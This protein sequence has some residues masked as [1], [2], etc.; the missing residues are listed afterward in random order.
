[1]GVFGGWGLS[2]ALVGYVGST[3]NDLYAT[4]RPPIAHLDWSMIGKGFGVA[5]GS[6]LI[7][8]AIPL[9]QASRTAPINSLRPTD[10]RDRSHR[11][12]WVLLAAGLFFLAAAIVL[13]RLPGDSPAIGFLMALL[14]ASG[15]A[16]LCPLAT[17]SLASLAGFIGRRAQMM[18]IQ[19]AA[20]GVGHSLR[21]TGVAVAAMMLAAAMNVALLTMIGSFRTAVLNW[22][23]Q[24][25]RSDVFVAPELQIDYRIDSV[26]DPRVVTWIEAQ[27]ET[28]DVLLYRRRALRIGSV[29][30]QLISTQVSHVL[31]RHMLPFRFEP[32]PGEAF[33]PQAD[34]LVSEPL[35]GKL[36]VRPGQMLDVETP[37][38]PRAF[39]IF[40]IYFD[41]ASDRGEAML[42]RAAYAEF[43]NDRSVSSVHVELKNPSQVREVVTRW[44][45]EL[46]PT[47]PV[48][49]HN[50]APREIG[51]RPHLRPDISR[52]RC[53]RMDGGRS[54]FLWTGWR[55]ASPLD[56]AAARV[57][58]P[59]ALGMSGRQT[60]AWVAMEGA[61]IAIVATL[62][63]CAA[64]TALAYILAYV[65]QY[66]SFGWS[67]PMT[68]QPRLWL[69]ALGWSLAAAV[70]AA[71]YPILRLRHDP[72]AIGL[73]QE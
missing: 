28:A 4:I 10:Q 14:A 38:G 60:A 71:I 29:S 11:A 70:L 27:P 63:A 72:P 69:E 15:F 65:I 56:G 61:V 23:D 53:S 16:M 49:V 9:W 59:R 73:R 40:A 58:H 32:S 55:F 33:D 39:R 25:F 5:L 8:A 37:S 26:L 64:G 6:G 22:L 62:V 3:I 31:K 42:D 46:E 34:I 19:M 35:A 30:T 1:M 43:W 12:A 66:R 36:K 13:E 48:L 57:R 54:R 68:L 47:Y 44:A 50:Y 41:F 45:A 7:G 21:V 17:L 51:N 52:D 24:R 18:P 20:A 67:I 2:A